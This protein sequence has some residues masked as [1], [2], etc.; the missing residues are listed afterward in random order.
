MAIDIKPKEEKKYKLPDSFNALFYYSIVLLLFSVSAYLLISQW[1]SEIE[2]QIDHREEFVENLRGEEEFEERRDFVYDRRNLM[3]DYLHLYYN[4]K[5]LNNFFLFL[6]ES[7][8]PAAHLD[9]VTLDTEDGEVSVTGYTL[10]F[11]TLEQ[12]HTILKEFSFNREIIG[13]VPEYH[14]SPT[15]KFDYQTHLDFVE[16]EEAWSKRIENWDEFGE[17]EIF[18]QEMD[19]GQIRSVIFLIDEDMDEDEEGAY[20][21]FQPNVDIV[22]V[23]DEDGEEKE[24]ITPLRN[25]VDIYESPI[26]GMQRTSVDKENIRNVDEIPLL[27]VARQEDYRTNRKDL[28]D[29]DWYEVLIVENV[30]PIEEVELV[31]VSEVQG[32]FSV[33]FS[34]QI[35]LDQE[36]FKP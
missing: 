27:T 12:Q 14:P 1:N 24:R 3:N 33:E 25:L 19:D 29:W 8:H 28:L 13:W 26:L 35:K 4:K 23:E 31:G 2:A 32:D 20:Q 16:D 10:D 22:T 36:I 7:V 30:E 15:D 17:V 21:R 9:T 5:T 18:E 6:E 34:F 11:N